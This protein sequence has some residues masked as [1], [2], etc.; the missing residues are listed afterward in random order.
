MFVTIC[1]KLDFSLVNV[2]GSDIADG[3]LK[4]MLAV[5]DQLMRFHIV[6]FLEVLQNKNQE[7]AEGSAFSDIDLDAMILHW[8]NHVLSSAESRNGAPSNKPR[9]LKTFRQKSLFD[10]LLLLDLLWAMLPRAVPWREV[11]TNVTSNQE[12]LQNAR[13]LVSCAK[14]IGCLI[15][16]RPEH[17]V[18]VRSKFV[19]V[20]VA[21][22]MM[23]DISR[24]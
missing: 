9:V 24:D 18:N 19:L 5:L 12:A 1:K 21:A 7:A 3:S 10:S 23:K 20:F 11:Y 16:T 15:F 17:I 22:L 4:I 6:H 13:L 2:S 14:K 8:A